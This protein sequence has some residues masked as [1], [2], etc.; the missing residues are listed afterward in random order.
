MSDKKG[1]LSSFDELAKKLED[2]CKV[3]SIII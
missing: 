2:D 1:T 3:V